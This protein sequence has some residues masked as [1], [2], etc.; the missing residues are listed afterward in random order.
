LER[1]SS[2]SVARDGREMLLN[3][4]PEARREILKLLKRQGPLPV[5]AVADALGVTVS[6]A[7]QHLS[8][9]EKD[10]V[11]TYQRI[12]EGPGR[13]R[14]MYE[15]TPEGDALFPRGYP[16][17]TR[18][19]L[20]YV[21]EADPTLLDQLFQRRAQRRVREAYRRLEGLSFPDKVRAL[22][23]FLEEEGYMPEVVRINGADDGWRIV[24][25]N[26]VMKG[27]GER[28]RGACA[29]EIAFIRRALPDA[30][31]QRVSHVLQEKPCCAYEIRQRAEQPAGRGVDD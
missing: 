9:L 16:E 27:L 24:E 22:A 14:H 11:V 13:P 10:G 3:L 17:L 12:R 21:Q 7:R 25:R 30:E 6:G 8:G 5:E 26:C 2:I 28:Y 4:I 31:V 23:E 19:L 1:P 18:E 15:L 29:S 20:E